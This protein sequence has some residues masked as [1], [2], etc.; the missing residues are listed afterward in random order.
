M[1]AYQVQSSD[2]FKDI[3]QI[4]IEK[5]ELAADEILVRMKA[6]SLNYRDLLIPLGGYPRNEMCPVIPL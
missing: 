4:E 5:P 1:K 3:K 2:G 6:C